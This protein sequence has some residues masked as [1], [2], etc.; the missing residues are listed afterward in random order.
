MR[1]S[2]YKKY[3]RVETKDGP[4]ISTEV[5]LI[6]LESIIARDPR[7]YYK[8]IVED[9]GE[10]TLDGDIGGKGT[11]GGFYYPAKLYKPAARQATL[12][13]WA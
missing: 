10:L 11:I 12:E 2:G 9:D 8:V 7:M 4:A 5:G 6:L 3:P 1:L 13:E